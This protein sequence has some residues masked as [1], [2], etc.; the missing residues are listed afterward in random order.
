[1]SGQCSPDKFLHLLGHKL[2]V[3]Y[4]G[5]DQE[6]DGSD[7]SIAEWVVAQVLQPA[8]GGNFSSLSAHCRCVDHLAKRWMSS[9]LLHAMLPEEG[10]LR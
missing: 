9:V 6:N 2:G 8:G 1:M 4:P 7:I 10:D 3:L 5:S